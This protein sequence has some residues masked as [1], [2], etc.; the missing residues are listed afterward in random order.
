[1]IQDGI[2]YV[3]NS[4]TSVYRSGE[5]IEFGPLRDSDF[6]LLSPVSGAPQH[7]SFGC[8][9]NAIST[10]FV[11]SNNTGGNTPST[12][13]HSRR[14]LVDNF[15]FQPGSDCSNDEPTSLSRQITV[16]PNFTI[17][18]SVKRDCNSFGTEHRRV[19]SYDLILS[20]TGNAYSGDLDLQI[21]TNLNVNAIFVFDGRTP[22]SCE[23]S[24]NAVRSE[25]AYSVGSINS[26]QVVTCLL[27][28]IDFE[29]QTEIALSYQLR[30]DK[31]NLVGSSDIP[32]I[33]ASVSAWGGQPANAISSDY[34]AHCLEVIVDP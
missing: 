19:C 15:Q 27:E 24:N 23:T 12:F 7:P 34:P 18:Q 26:A 33:C 9:D 29:A 14:L 8:G 32:R 20:N 4:G 25:F 17:D 13:M 28:N 31:S 5:V 21:V 3:A 6:V 2:A 1:L 10:G 22:L 16:Q 11:T 30:A